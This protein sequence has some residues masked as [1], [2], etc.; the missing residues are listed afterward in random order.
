LHPV[1]LWILVIFLVSI[2]FAS[3]EIS[4]VSGM[5]F[6]LLRCIT[7]MGNC[8]SCFLEILSNQKNRRPHDENLAERFLYVEGSVFIPDFLSTGGITEQ[9]NEYSVI[10]F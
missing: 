5:F 6:Q 7:Q 1:I 8:R 3:T 4:S 10:T 9:K 2:R